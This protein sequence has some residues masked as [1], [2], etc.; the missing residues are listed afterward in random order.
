M[1]KRGVLVEEVMVVAV[2]SMRAVEV[3]ACQYA[4]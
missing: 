1:G 4:R 2:E 3:G